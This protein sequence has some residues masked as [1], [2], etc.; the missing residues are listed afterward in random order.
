VD[1]I[2]AGKDWEPEFFVAPIYKV[3]AY[4]RVAGD[5]RAGDEY[6]LETRRNYYETVI[7]KQP[8]WDYAG[9]YADEGIIGAEAK[10][11]KEFQRMV[12]DYKA[13]KIDL[14]L[15]KDIT[16][17]SNS[18]T[19]SMK[20]IETLLAMDPLVGLYFEEMGINTLTASGRTELLG[21]VHG[22]QIWKAG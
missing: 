16:S 1:P 10:N 12:A 18:L 17:F 4:A 2:Y 21:I 20:K 13:G 22:R 14:I 3:A 7:H 6:S 9:F 19:S 15:V 8:C 5:R 11:D